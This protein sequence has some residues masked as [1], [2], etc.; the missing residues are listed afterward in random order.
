MDICLNQF[1]SKV[2]VLTVPYSIG[3]DTNRG[4]FCNWH[5]TSKLC[6]P[7]KTWWR[8]TTVQCHPYKTGRRPTIE[9]CHPFKTGRLST[10]VRSHPFKTVRRS[11]TELCH[12]FKTGRRPTIELCHPF[13]TVQ[14][15]C[16]HRTLFDWCGHQPRTKK[17]FCHIQLAYK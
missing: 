3:E 2:A 13:K 11:I 4:Q 5:S 12:P 14:G 16:P 7:F 9:L 8:F 17:L 15:R 6:H 1:L 10:T